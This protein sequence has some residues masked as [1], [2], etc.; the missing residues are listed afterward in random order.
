[1]AG[2]NALKASPD[3]V[4]FTGVRSRSLAPVHVPTY[5]ASFDPAAAAAIALGRGL[6]EA[7]AVAVDLAHLVGLGDLGKDGKHFAC[8]GNFTKEHIIAKARHLYDAGFS[9]KDVD[10][11]IRT[12]V[13]G[14]SGVDAAHYAICVD[15]FNGRVVDAHPV[16]L[17]DNNTQIYWTRLYNDQTGRAREALF[18]PRSYGDND[19]WGRNPMEY[20]AYALNRMLGMDLV[21]PVA[22]R[23]NVE[24]DYK[25]FGE[26]AMIYMV[27]DAHLLKGVPEQEWGHRKDLFLSDARI[28]DILIQN[29]DRHR[30][31]YI[32]GRHWVDGAYRPMLID[33]GAGLRQGTYLTLDMNNAFLTGGVEKIRRRTFDAL[34]TLHYDWLRDQVGEFLS[35]DE[36]RGILE[37][38]DQIV[39]HF[40]HRIRE[41]GWENV[42]VG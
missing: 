6:S 4:P 15:L 23:R 36:I 33:H 8:F 21:P 26:G 9:S 10:V 35:H 14:S 24:L 20:V 3:L 27:P 30:G 31:N 5:A 28:L 38:R 41:R 13:A 29:P 17:N 18:K 32:R 16:N 12:G 25:H 40:E 34:K 7:E 1:M 39:G 37:R 2:A 42:V 19:G 22:Y 11:L